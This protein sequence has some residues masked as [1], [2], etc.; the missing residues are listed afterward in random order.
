VKA[1]RGKDALRRLRQ[2]RGRLLVLGKL[3]RSPHGAQEINLPSPGEASLKKLRDQNQGE[4]GGRMVNR[5]VC[6]P[7]G[8]VWPLQI[9]GGKVYTGID[10]RSF[11][12]T[13]IQMPRSQP[14]KDSDT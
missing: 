2:T 4:R 12:P 3:I 7:Q 10:E 14:C 13:G 1:K 9:E 5:H 6:N 8:T 11:L